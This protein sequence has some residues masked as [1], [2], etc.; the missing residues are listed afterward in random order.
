MWKHRR[1][2]LQANAHTEQYRRWEPHFLPRNHHSTKFSHVPILLVWTKC[3]LAPIDQ[4]NVQTTMSLTY[5]SQ[6]ASNSQGI[7]LSV[8]L[9]SAQYVRLSRLNNCF[10]TTS[11]QYLYSNACLYIGT[12]NKTFLMEDVCHK[13]QNCMYRTK[14]CWRL[15]CNSVVPRCSYWL[16]RD[17]GSN[18]TFTR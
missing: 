14:D 17:P 1:Q 13:L 6:H 18:F 2:H 5:W 3:Q 16:L 4:A 12:S 9:I 7:W 11:Y 10:Y 8:D 15:F